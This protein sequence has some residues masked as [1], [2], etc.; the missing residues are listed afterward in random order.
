MPQGIPSRAVARASSSKRGPPSI[1]RTGNMYFTIACFIP[2]LLRG[3][4]IRGPLPSQW[5]KIHA[6]N[7]L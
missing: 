6:G 7:G 2:R 5:P 4:L 3:V 1:A